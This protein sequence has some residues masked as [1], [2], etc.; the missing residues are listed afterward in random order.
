MSEYTEDTLVQQTTA[1]YLHDKLGWESVYA[2]NQETFGP[3]GTLGRTSDREVVLTRYLRTKLE[4]LNPGLPHDA[5]RDARRQIIETSASQTMLAT[6]REK[7]SLLKD[8][9]Q[10]S[11]RDD[12]GELKK[13]GLEEKDLK[14]ITK[15][16]DKIITEEIKVLTPELLDKYYGKENNPRRNELSNEL[17]KA[18]IEI[19]KR[20]DKGYNVEIRIPT[21]DS[22]EDASIDQHIKTISTVLKNLEFIKLEGEPVLSLPETI[23]E[24][25]E[26]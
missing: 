4:E 3:D 26:E 10:V 9:V 17:N 2:Y 16:A 6:N 25:K 23:E 1:E 11:F 5:Y 22:S 19:A 12:K 20:I 24:G 8:G 7:H 14:G 15:K 18:L 13:Q 21:K